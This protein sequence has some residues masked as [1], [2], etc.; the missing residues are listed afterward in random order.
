MRLKLGLCK[1]RKRIGGAP[2]TLSPLTANMTENST[3][4]T[5]VIGSF[6]Y[7]PSAISLVSPANSLAL[8]GGQLVAGSAAV[9]YETNTVATCR[10][11]YNPGGGDVTA[12]V[13]VTILNQNAPATPS[14][15]TV[16]GA[17]SSS[18]Q[19]TLASDPASDTTITRRD[20]RYG[21][22][23]TSWTQVTGVSSPHTI[24]GLLSSTAYL[25]QWRAF[26][27]EG[28]GGWSAS[29][30]G[31]TFAAGSGIAPEAMN[32]PGLW[33]A[34]STAMDVLI[35]GVPI[36]VNLHDSF[37]V[38]WS[39]NADFTG[40]TT[41]TGITSQ[42]TQITGITSSSTGTRIYVRCYAVQGGV[43]SP[44][45]RSASAWTHPTNVIS[46]GNQAAL[47]SQLTSLSPNGGAILELAD[48][49]YTG[50]TISA[51]YN[52]PVFIRSA[53]RP[54]HSAYT[55]RTG[56]A[57]FLATGGVDAVTI[58]AASNVYFENIKGSA[59]QVDP[60][61]SQ[62]ALAVVKLSGSWNRIG[63]RRCEFGGSTIEKT[64][65]GYSWSRVWQQSD[66]Q[67]GRNLSLWE[68]WFHDADR[69]CIMALQTTTTDNENCIY[70]NVSLDCYSYGMQLSGGSNIID[71]WNYDQN[72]FSVDVGFDTTV[73]GALTATT[74]STVQLPNVS[75]VTVVPDDGYKYMML[76]AVTGPNTG[77]FVDVT[78]YVASTRTIT[79]SPAFTN[80]PST[81][82]RYRMRD[83]SQAHQS[84]RPMTPK[85]GDQLNIVRF[86]NV[87][88]GSAYRPWYCAIAGMKLDDKNNATDYYRRCWQYG[89]LNVASQS[90][91]FEISNGDAESGMVYN[92]IVHDENWARRNSPA[93]RVSGGGTSYMTVENNISA[94]LSPTGV[95]VGVGA[96]AGVG[97]YYN[98]DNNIRYNRADLTPN[99]SLASMFDGPSF[100]GVQGN[101]L[102]IFKNKTGGP[103]LD[104]SLGSLGAGALGGAVTFP[105]GFKDLPRAGSLNFRLPR[106]K[107]AVTIGNVT[108]AAGS[109]VITSSAVVVADVSPGTQVFFGIDNSGGTA[110]VQ[111]LDTDG[112][113]VVT[114]WTT[115]TWTN[116]KSSVTINP[117]Q[118][119]Q[120]RLT[121]AASGSRDV[122]VCIGTS[123]RVW[124]VTVGAGDTTP[125]V[126]SSP[127]GA[128]TGATS[129]SWGVT[130]NEGNGTL[131]RVTTTSA[132]QP[133]AAQ[134][135]AGQDHTGAAANNGSTTVTATGVQSGTATGLTTGVT[136]YHHFVHRDAALNDSNV[137]SSAGFTP[138]SGGGG[139]A[140][141]VQQTVNVL[142]TSNS[143]STYTGTTG[144]LTVGSAANRVL[145]FWVHGYADVAATAPTISAISLGSDTPTQVIAPQILAGRVWGALFQLINPASGPAGAFSITLSNLQR[146]I[147]CTVIE[148]SGNNQTTPVAGSSATAGVGTSRSFTYATTVANALM[149]SSIQIDRGAEAANI[150]ATGGATLAGTPS[151]TGTLG[152]SDVSF[153]TAELTVATLGNAGGHG[154]SW[155]TSDDNVLL[156]AELAPA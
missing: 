63:A 73:D 112:S 135:K 1:N 64:A 50:I 140:P 127:T 101:V 26:S 154:Y 78:G 131:F 121:T 146:A 80:T 105:T 39:V 120:V 4:G 17:S 89:N 100:A 27:G 33:P 75:Q 56:G 55:D 34:S 10:L 67:L 28:A 58:S 145:Y 71:A 98:G 99:P 104:P 85:A 147:A 65:R 6:N 47:V 3:A 79:F 52:N 46:V 129:A 24:S 8:S 117:G 119:L 19:V 2:G 92:T 70:G 118:Y 153:G 62:R 124:T 114:A 83:P 108:G 72:F 31:S 93:T 40:S 44:V 87:Y 107:S 25:V 130:T 116:G 134:I 30:T 149:L 22:D 88:G 13:T 74:A 128:A 60:A 139:S 53:T 95:D 11:T 81:A 152:T 41:I 113:T 82:D 61:V 57:V 126:L 136:Y 37:S 96:Q 84:A 97:I 66:A 5:V 54:T 77:E 16:A 20:I 7:T 29:G 9:D 91:S 125:P 155:T 123:Q 109:S 115:P 156:Y 15:P 94:G 110:Q 102:T 137:V 144:L 133:S 35:P 141:V 142:N 150:T 18:V 148:V 38:E 86:G 138:T 51:S 90:I 43:S 151:Q 76:E 143:Q 122:E 48:G 21:T 49:N 106:R 32:A 111:V 69:A 68:N 36:S 42:I 23:G 12:D 14:A 45:G 103:A 132:T 59:P